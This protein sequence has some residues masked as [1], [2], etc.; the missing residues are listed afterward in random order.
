MD[1][2][3][4]MR[5]ALTF[6]AL[7]A[8]VRVSQ[9][10]KTGRVIEV[11]RH[12]MLTIARTAV[13]IRR[14]LARNMRAAGVYREGLLDAHFRRS[15]DQLCMIAHVV[16]AGV[17]QSGC[18][19]RFR[20]DETF[21][22]VEQAWAAKKGVIH[23]AP[24]ICGYP[25]YAS[26]VSPRIPCCAYLRRNAD[27]RKRRIDEEVTSAWEGEIVAPPAGA[28]RAQRLQVAIS[29]LRKGKMLF[30]T[31]DTPRKPHRGVP[32]TIFGRRAYFPSGAFVMA[33]RTGA[34][35]VPVFWRW[36]G[37]A[38]H[39]HYSEPFEIKRNGRVSQQI[40]AAT[41]AWAESVDSFLHEHPAMWWNWL[42]KRWTYILRNDRC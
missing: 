40:E 9:R 1:L 15:I 23:I 8:M 32:V 26:I 25:L 16:R 12:G 22:H 28:S 20:F 3:R 18:L 42:D 30:V 34:P 39:I 33:A 14:R 38:Y 21:L 6:A 5:K 13:P 17:R 7:K 2:T 27:P 4:S 29:V 36:A 35:V 10:A 19:E 41:K 31:P 11:I 24:H 37:D